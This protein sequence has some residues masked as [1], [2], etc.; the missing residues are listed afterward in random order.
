MSH[1]P[2]AIEVLAESALGT[3]AGEALLVQIRQHPGRTRGRKRI[4]S[5]I[6]TWSYSRSSS[7]S[8]T[9]QLTLLDASRSSPSCPVLPC[10]EIARV[11]STH[12]PGGDRPLST[13]PPASGGSRGLMGIERTRLGSLDEVVL[14]QKKTIRYMASSQ[15]HDPAVRLVRCVAW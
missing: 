3:G 13:G 15:A 12:P 7:E 14:Q 4:D 2:R 10:E 5:S 11:R 1:Y 8:R 6:T 9:N